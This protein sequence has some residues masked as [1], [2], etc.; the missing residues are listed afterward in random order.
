MSSQS[1]ASGL[2]MPPIVTPL[3]LLMHGLIVLLSLSLAYTL[4][5]GMDPSFHTTQ[6]SCRWVSSSFTVSFLWGSAL[7]P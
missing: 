7:D 4:Y 1:P 3:S 6:P 5:D 2:V